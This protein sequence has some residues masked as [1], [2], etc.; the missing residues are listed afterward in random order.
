MALIPKISICFRDNCK[1]I[2]IT[3]T[4]GV[5][6]PALNIGGWGFPN[7]ALTDANPVNLTIT[8]PNG[9]SQT[10]NFTAIVNAA[11]IID[12]QF[13]LADLTPLDFTGF[14]GTQFEDGVYNFSYVVTDSIT[15]TQYSYN[16]KGF[17]TCRAECCLAK[18]LSNLCLELCSCDGLKALEEYNVAEAML[19]AAKCAFGAGN[20]TVA[21]SILKDVNKICEIKKCQC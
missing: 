17:N 21:T 13:L 10:F 9:T 18:L 11:T 20:Y 4:T 15:L 16:F 5:Y 12:G 6:D 3:E 8:F 7:T 1:T 2:R 14:I 19:Y